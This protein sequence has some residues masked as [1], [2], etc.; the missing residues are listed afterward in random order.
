VELHPLVQFYFTAIN[1]IK[2][3]SGIL[4]PRATWDMTQNLQATLGANL[5]YGAPDTE[6]GGILIPG[7]TIRAR[8]VDSLYLWLTYYF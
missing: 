2:D 8:P 5:Y 1:N 4:Q 6:F 7:T 3:P